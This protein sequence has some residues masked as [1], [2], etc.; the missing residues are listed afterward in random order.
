[1]C[2]LIGREKEIETLKR[3]YNSTQS[4]FVAIYGRRRVGKTFLVDETFKGKLTF[5]HSGLS[6]VD[7]KGKPHLLKDQLK[8]FYRSLLLQ[9]MKKSHCPTSWGD[10][11]FMLEQHL[12]SIDNG[13]RQVVFLDELPWMDTPHSGFITALEGY[14]NSWACQRSN[15]M[16]IVCGSATSWVVDN[17]INNHGG[18]YGRL[19]YEIKL[20]P[21]SLC[22]C[23][24]F[25]KK[26]GI[27]MSRYD[28]VQSYMILGGIPYYLNYLDNKLSM[29]QNIDTLFF[30]SN[31]KLKDEYDRLFSSVFK[32]PDEMKR[33]VE[34]LYTR[35]A[36][37]TRMEILKG[38]GIQ[39]G[40]ALT[41]CLRALIASDFVVKYVP[42]GVSTRYERYK[43]IDPFCMFYIHF[44]SGKGNI[45]PDLWASGN[46]QSVISWRGYAFEEL[47]FNHINQIR[48]ALSIGGVNSTISAFTIDGD[49]KEDGAQIDL[50]IN[51]SDNVVNMC[52]IKFYNDDFAVT[53]DYARVLLRRQNVLAE[54]LPK[55][56]V[57]H[58]TLITTYGLKDNEYC[59]SFT[60]TVTIDDL[61]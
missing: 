2:N 6:P 3:L 36:G 32:N 17:L 46:Q 1:M 26:N 44:L 22:E 29:S 35:R 12:R 42:F 40:G 48:A 14:W 59:G 43:V 24:H 10:A 50:L 34:F 41:K 52:E 51:R 13:K 49:C 56:V 27:R 58:P 60:S 18:L 55:K 30:N 28:M 47:C 16:L 7:D 9:G 37:Y 57:V 8:H 21:F 45:T 31:A 5:R 38:L 54:K 20:S 23:E 4:Q 61:F 25:Y 53:K 15:L 39:E 19:T 11:F 33:I